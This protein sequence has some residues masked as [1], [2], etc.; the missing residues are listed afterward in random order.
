MNA[1]VLEKLRKEYPKGT[2]VKLVQ[3]DDAYAPSVGT[4]CRVQHIDATGSIHVKWDNGSSLAVLYGVDSCV[5]VS[6]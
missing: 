1:D 3:M 5:K 4:L 2:R 6:E